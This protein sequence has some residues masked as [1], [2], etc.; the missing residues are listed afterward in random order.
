MPATVPPMLQ[1]FRHDNHN[2]ALITLAGEIDLDSAPLVG[3]SLERC[4]HDGIS[5]V[6]ID[7]T[8]VTFCDCSG[9]NAFLYALL[10]NAGAGGYLRLHYPSPALERLFALTG[11]GSLF[12][13]LP[14]PHAGNSPTPQQ[15]SPSPF[16]ES[17]FTPVARTLGGGALVVAHPADRAAG[18]PRDIR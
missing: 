11:S 14:D 2:H 18:A 6:D 1:V 10:R 4:L 13:S 7:L 17:P 12:L 15:P 8:N 16:S 5:A 3:A 9:L